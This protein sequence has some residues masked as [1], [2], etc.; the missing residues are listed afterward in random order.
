MNWIVRPVAVGTAADT[1]SSLRA[2]AAE[3]LRL[4]A[5]H[6][7]RTMI[8]ELHQLARRY[9]ERAKE[10]EGSGAIQPAVPS[11]IKVGKQE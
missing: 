4:A 10:L 6:K 1:P 9:M 7:D 2:K 5:E 3:F 8:E 11:E